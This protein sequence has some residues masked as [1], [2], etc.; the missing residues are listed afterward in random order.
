MKMMGRY[1][2]KG[3]VILKHNPGKCVIRD[4]CKYVDH[5]EYVNSWL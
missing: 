2:G 5:M 1:K 3:G 4:V